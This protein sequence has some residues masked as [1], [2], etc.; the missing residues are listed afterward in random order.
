MTSEVMLVWEGFTQRN[1]DLQREERSTEV[2]Q[3]SD[4]SEGTWGGER[5]LM[6]VR[7]VRHLDVVKKRE[8]GV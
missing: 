2:P 5:A 8:R 3:A 4:E 6:Q 1:L 7:A